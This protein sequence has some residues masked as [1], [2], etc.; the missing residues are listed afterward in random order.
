MKIFS[1]ASIPWH[2]SRCV[3][4]DVTD[5]PDKLVFEHYIHYELYWAHKRILVLS[6]TQINLIRLP[7]ML[8]GMKQYFPIEIFAIIALDICRGYWSI[9]LSVLVPEICIRLLNLN[10]RLADYICSF[11]SSWW[12]VQKDSC[13]TANFVNL[14]CALEIVSG[15]RLDLN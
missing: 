11:V 7:W 1:K 8:L 13:F 14:I 15:P 3:G 4:Y 2:I 5:I 6:D 10:P 12:N 9:A